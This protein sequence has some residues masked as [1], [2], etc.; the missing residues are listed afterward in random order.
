MIG[1]CSTTSLLDSIQIRWWVNDC[2][3][4][5]MWTSITSMD[6]AITGVW[7]R[8]YGMARVTRAS[9]EALGYGVLVGNGK[10]CVEKAQG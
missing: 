9:G 7:L 1:I 3:A 8:D 5:L 6:T 2:T 4:E 10:N